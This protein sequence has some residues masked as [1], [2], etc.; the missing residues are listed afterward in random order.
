MRNLLK[1]CIRKYCVLEI[2]E[3]PHSTHSKQSRSHIPG[4]TKES[5]FLN[6]TEFS[7]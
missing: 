3:F 4:L 7:S 5:A 2:F 6:F 1:S